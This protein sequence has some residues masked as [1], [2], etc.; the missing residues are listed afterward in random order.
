[1]KTN[2]S[3]RELSLEKDANVS[4]A[5]LEEEMAYWEEEMGY[6]L[7]SIQSH[8]AHDAEVQRRV[9]SQR[10]AMEDRQRDLDEE[11]EARLWG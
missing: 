11:R 1:M 5:D 3:P 2:L 8:R 10:K 6:V 7:S 9:E 4:F